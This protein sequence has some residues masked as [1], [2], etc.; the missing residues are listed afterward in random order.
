VRADLERYRAIGAI[1]TA[2]TG[3]ACI[4]IHDDFL[5]D[6]RNPHGG[7]LLDWAYD[8]LGLVTFSTELW[9]L[10]LHVGLEGA[11][12]PLDF[13]FGKT[14]TED[15]DLAMLH[16]LDTHLD[17]VGYLPWTPFDHPQLG[18]VEIG[19]W[20]YKAVI[21]N[22]P[23]PVLPSVCESNMRFTL[24]AAA[25]A[26][27]L[28]VS[29]VRV[30][31][32]TGDAWRLSAL[33]ENAGYLPTSVTDRAV[34][35][36]AV[37]PVKAVLKPGAGLS[38]LSGEPEQPLGHLPGRDGQSAPA[39]MSVSLGWPNRAVAC[40]IVE[41][42]EGAEVAIEAISDRAGTARAIATLR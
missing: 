4:A 5:T 29:E 3:Y 16:W 12:R 37:R 2:E 24:R 18:P 1:G 39:P 15:D 13:Y 22:A 35:V 26:P 28:V 27:R 6:K 19:G 11:K 38:R 21:Q 36:G 40:W 17:G 41:G 8:H 9:S 25:C 30:E 32:L 14:R 20:D 23:G 42:P 34:T 10:G 7:L 33:V 31:R